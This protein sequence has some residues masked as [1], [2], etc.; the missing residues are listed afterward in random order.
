MNFIKERVKDYF[1]RDTNVE[2]IFINEYMAQAPGDYVKVYL[3]ALMY[4]DFDAQMSNETMAKHLNL[5]VEDMLKAWSYWEELGLIKKHYENPKDPFRYQVEILNLKE[6]FYGKKEKR[7]KT[8]KKVPDHVKD[9]LDNDGLKDMYSEI[10]RITG[11][12]LGGKEP[13]EIFAW[14]TDYNA[15]PEMIVYAYSYS[16]KRKGHGDYRY[17][18]TIVKEWAGQGL[19]TIDKIESFLEET[20]NRHYQYKRILKALGFMRNPTEE[21]KRIIDSWFDEM[22]FD[23]DKILEAC[24]KTSGISNPNINYINSVLKAWKGGKERPASQ[25]EEGKPNQI[26]SVLKHYE[27]LRAKNERLAEARRQEVYSQIPRIRQIDEEARGIGLEIS[28]VMLSGGLTAKGKIKALKEQ[29]DFLNQEKAFLMT[30]NNFKIDYM[31]M[32]YS[33]TLCNDTGILDTGQ[34]CSCF[35]EKLSSM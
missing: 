32:V 8:D 34:R 13:S 28:K 7:K 1:L 30:E 10:E 23:M 27:E 18:G 21:E 4:A 26:S 16:M 14:I 15:T 2:N 19:K 25:V 35:A 5:P 6:R 3:L 24:K 31:D 9:M 22:G 29:V 17:V 11:R 20:D 12:L 33:C